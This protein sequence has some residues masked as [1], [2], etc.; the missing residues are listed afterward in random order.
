MVVVYIYIY[1]TRLLEFYNTSFAECKVPPYYIVTKANHASVLFRGL[2]RSPG[3]VCVWLSFFGVKPWAGGLQCWMTRLSPLLP[4]SKHST[5][6]WLNVISVTDCR[7]SESL[8]ACTVMVALV[9]DWEN[10]CDSGES[11]CVYLFY[12][13]WP[14]FNFFISVMWL[15]VSVLLLPNSLPSF[16]NDLTTS[17]RSSPKPNCAHLPWKCTALQDWT[18]SN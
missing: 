15:C 6:S 12:H 17:W 14:A 16:L 9:S 13:V 5:V 7:S 10:D 8:F 11:S 1:I 18:C 2:V 3:C 4:S